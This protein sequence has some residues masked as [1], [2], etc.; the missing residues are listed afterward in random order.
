LIVYIIPAEKPV[1][2]GE[3]PVGIPEIIEEVLWKM[4]E[5]LPS[6][7]VPTHMEAVEGNFPIL[8]SGKV[9]R[10]L[11]PVPIG[12]LDYLFQLSYRHLNSPNVTY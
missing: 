11:L 7:M 2:S 4:K 3:E 9:N 12:E 8:P 6:Y 10:K 5:G 1:S